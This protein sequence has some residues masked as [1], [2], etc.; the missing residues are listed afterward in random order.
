[1]FFEH[2]QKPERAFA[3]DFDPELGVRRLYELFK[4]RSLQP[5]GE[6]A[7]QEARL[8]RNLQN[9]RRYG[10]NPANAAEWAQIIERLIQIA[11][12]ELGVN[13]NDLCHLLYPPNMFV[14]RVEPKGDDKDTDDLPPA[15][16]YVCRQNWAV[17]VGANAYED[18]ANYPLLQVCVADATALAQQFIA[19]GFLGERIR[20]ITDDNPNNRPTRG[21]ILNSLNA[22]AAATQPDD[23]L[24]FYYSG[25]GD[26][27]ENESYLVSYDGWAATLKH[28]A[29]SFSDVK[30]IMQ[31]APARN[32]V[33]ILDACHAGVSLG[34]KG[35]A[36]MSPAFISRVFEEAEGFV[37]LSSCTRNQ[38]SYQSS[39]RGQSIY[40][41]FLLRALQGQADNEEKGLVTV[42]DINNYV[43]DKVKAWAAQQKCIQSPTISTEM[44]GEIIV[45]SYTQIS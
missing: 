7:I 1:L 22:V 20:V 27:D 3:M 26:V 4:H 11:D 34:S 42:C 32:K 15:P 29:V 19:N 31:Q 36:Q 44:S 21:N 39:Q 14:P 40:T 18:Q 5:S 12:E 30:Q 23:L 45:C 41:H 37:V 43:T 17:F 28:T 2:E 16:N 33:V 24:L 38:L 35:K 9:N 6:L 10:E 25:H 8:R 13:F